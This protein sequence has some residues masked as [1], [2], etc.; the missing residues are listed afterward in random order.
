[1]KLNL[2]PART[3]IVWVKL[4][5]R[6]FFRQPLALSGLFFMFALPLSLVGL[7]PW[8]GFFLQTVLLPAG[9]LG[10][11]VAT[12]QAEQGRFP[13][14]NV[15]LS[16]F[17][18]GPRRTR[19]MLLL[20]LCWALGVAAVWGVAALI[21]GGELARYYLAGEALNPDSLMEPRLQ[22][23]MLVVLVLNLLLTAAFW[24]SPALTYFGD[25]PPLKSFFFSVVASMR[26]FGAYLVY[27][28]L[29][30][31]VMTLAFLVIAILLLTL[32]GEGLVKAGM[33][34]LLML[35]MAMTFTSIFFTFRDSFS[36]D[37]ATDDQGPAITTPPEKP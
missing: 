7:I 23:A 18:G 10:M 35:L 21:D 4:G 34:P 17:T 25:L 37:D 12:Q 27:S 5:I 28:L 1:M 31:A 26:N 14:P 11:I 16:A 24:H 15:M 33:I 2:I 32:G 3:G 6:T 20:G 9:I 13:M 30:S 19:A 8:L 36:L 29:W 22:W